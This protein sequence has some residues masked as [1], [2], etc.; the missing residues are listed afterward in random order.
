[1]VRLKIINLGK[2]AAKSACI[3]NY[4]LHY[5]IYLYGILRQH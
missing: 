5:F 4:N 2:E 3:I 1:M